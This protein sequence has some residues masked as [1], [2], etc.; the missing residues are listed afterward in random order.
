M[1]R[2]VEQVR[3]RLT[4]AAVLFA[5]GDIDKV[6][7]E[8]LGNKARA[9]LEAA[10]AAQDQIKKLHR[11]FALPPLETVLAAA[12]GCGAALHRGDIATQR[13]VLPALI[14][15]IVP[16]QVGRGRYTAEITRTPLG[17][18]LRAETAS[19]MGIA[20]RSAA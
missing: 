16:V 6:G 2:D 17:E 8:L 5:D 4:K 10:T 15:Q 9:D 18:G 12:E 1:E 13:E 11:G 3:G 14:E 19:P 20:G 7:Y